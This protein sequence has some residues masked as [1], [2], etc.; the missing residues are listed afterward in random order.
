MWKL[1]FLAI[2]LI[3]MLVLASGCA[4]TKFN[5]ATGEIERSRILTESDIQGFLAEFD[6]ATGQWHVEWESATSEIS[7]TLTAL[8]QLGITIG[9]QMAALEA[10]LVA[11]EPSAEPEDPFVARMK[12]TGVIQ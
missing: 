11:L 2:C 8:V 1:K 10:G 12:S 9:K 5:P 7:D 3:A 6:P 4:V